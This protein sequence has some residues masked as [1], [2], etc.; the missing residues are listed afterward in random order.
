MFVTTAGRTNEEM[1]EQAKE[2]ADEL[3]IPF[4][5]RKKRSVVQLQ[6]QH[7]DSCIVVYKERMELYLLGESN[8]F[9]FHPSSA[10]FRIK[11]LLRGEHDPFI[12][13]CQLSSG[14]SFL[15][16]TIGL[17]SDSIVASYRVG[18][19]GKVIGLE[20]EKYL[21]YIVQDGLK[22]WSTDI[23]E[24][25]ESMRRIEVRHEHCYSYLKMLPSESIDVIYF[26]P[27]F[28]ET[29]AESI[30]IQPLTKIANYEVFQS[31]WIMEALRV[32]KNR[33]VLK[34]H[35]LSERFNLFGFKVMPRKTSK[36]HYGYIDK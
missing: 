9:F 5:E 17:G 11:R 34:D 21:S 32:A 3:Q 29:I 30:S 23:Q 25:N 15:D 13:A 20:A 1:I 18:S 26:D 2:I 28:E 24:I 19:S 10:M 8:P 12:E 36:F 27:M 6:E 35:Y 31:H 33:V 14:M 7:N 4:V 16:C 22:K